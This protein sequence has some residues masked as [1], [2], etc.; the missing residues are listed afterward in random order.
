MSK[1]PRTLLE[2]SRRTKGGVQPFDSALREFLDVF[3]AEPQRRGVAL[4][5]RPESI[6]AVHDAYLAATAEHLA[7]C[8]GLAVPPWSETHGNGLD[9][10]FFAG[11]LDA[12]KAILT[13]QSPAAFRR[14]LLFVSRDA[15]SRPRASARASQR[16]AT[17]TTS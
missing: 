5:E 10:P 8:Y 6:D 16:K 17:F 3:Y 2:V 13:V 4:E 1:R 9:R 15:L 12:L 11:G 7:R 14:R